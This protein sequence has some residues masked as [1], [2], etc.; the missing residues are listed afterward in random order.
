LQYKLGEKM[1]ED[2]NVMVKVFEQAAWNFDV[3]PASLTVS[4][5]SLPDQAKTDLLK[6]LT[7]K[8]DD[9]KDKCLTG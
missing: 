2:M 4:G 6:L 1:N 8:I 7:D 3:N 5:A 9:I